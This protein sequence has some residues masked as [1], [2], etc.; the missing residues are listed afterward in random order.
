[1][2]S[3]PDFFMATTNVA[4]AKQAGLDF[5]QLFTRAAEV[6]WESHHRQRASSGSRGFHYCFELE[7]SANGYRGMPKKCFRYG[8]THG[9]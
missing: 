5:G 9:V 8:M 7:H 4:T 3:I 1:M 2:I 6:T